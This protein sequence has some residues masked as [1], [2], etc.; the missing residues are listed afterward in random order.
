MFN[1]KVKVAPAS[2]PSQSQPKAAKSKSTVRPITE[3]DV[4][5]WFQQT[6]I[7][8]IKQISTLLRQH[9]LD[10]RENKLKIMGLLKKM[11]KKAGEGKIQLK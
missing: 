10:N 6:P 1:L 8:E 5:T 7:M 3:Q 4:R 2:P 9:H 11:T